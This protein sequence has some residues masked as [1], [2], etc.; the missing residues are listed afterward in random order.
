MSIKRQMLLNTI[1]TVF[2]LG[3]QWL[4][5]V[6][7]VRL[8][9]YEAA[10]KL[11]LAISITNV[12]SVI[13]LFTMRQYQVSDLENQYKDCIYIVSRYIT[14]LLSLIACMTYVGFRFTENE[15]ILCVLAYM[16]IKV[17]EALVDVYHGILQKKIRYDLMCISYVLRG[18]FHLSIFVIV[19]WKTGSLVLAL[20]MISVILLLIC[21]VYDRKNLAM[22]LIKKNEIEWGDLRELLKNCFP[23]VIFN[24]IITYIP[25]LPRLLYETMYG[26]D[27]LGVYGAVSAPAMIINVVA[28]MVF[29]PLIPVVKRTYQEKG[30]KYFHI[31]LLRIMGFIAVIGWVVMILVKLM[32]GVVLEFLFGDS[33]V[34]YVWILKPIALS[35]IVIAAVWIISN[36]LIT[37]RKIKELMVI[38]V[39]SILLELFF[40][41]RMLIKWE[42]NGISYCSILFLGMIVILA[43]VVAWFG[44]MEDKKNG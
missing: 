19:L 42:M 26:T 11:T 43:F 24:F 13:A 1:G 28:V 14:S 10:G 39:S 17:T 29:N 31:L 37:I 23:L 30:K 18:F 3:C 21:I 12:F 35:A 16:I 41:R 33:I 8:S 5:S 22:P 32:G 34:S 38:S 15:Q 20:S 2:Y 40:V 36:I 27:K 44:R 9:G 4:M 6:L 7:I 25:I